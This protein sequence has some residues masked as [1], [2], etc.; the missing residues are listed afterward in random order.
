MNNTPTDVYVT[1]GS[2]MFDD[3]ND[4]RVSGE[5]IWLDDHTEVAVVLGPSSSGCTEIALAYAYF[6][7]EISDAV[8][9]GD[10]FKLSP[11]QAQ[12]IAVNLLR[13]VAAC[14]DGAQPNLPG[15]TP[16]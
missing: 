2:L 6:N 9:G 7:P 13:A 3:S 14:G 4:W 12:W 15:M 8:G 5:S 16:G 1:R 10:I 11:E